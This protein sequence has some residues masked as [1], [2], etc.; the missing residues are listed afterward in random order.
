M[1]VVLHSSSSSIWC[2]YNNVPILRSRRNNGA[3]EGKNKE[4]TNVRRLALPTKKPVLLDFEIG[5]A[6]RGCSG[7]VFARK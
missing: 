6:A 4:S 3:S 5:M 7:T 1:V 2:Y